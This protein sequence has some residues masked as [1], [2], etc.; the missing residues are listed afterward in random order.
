MTD[1]SKSHKD[2]IP[3][4]E[5]KDIRVREGIA[6]SKALGLDD[7][8]IFLLN[9]EETK[10]QEHISAATSKVK[11]IIL[12]HQPDE[13]FI[14]YYYEQNFDHFVTNRAVISAVQT[15]PKSFHIY[16]Y[17]IWFWRFWPYFYGPI[18]TF[19]EYLHA[20]KRSIISAFRL[21][22]DF[23]CS[24][25]IG[26]VLGAKRN[27][28]NQHRSQMTQLIPNSD[29]PTLV[30]FEN[31]EFLARFFQEYEIFHRHTRWNDNI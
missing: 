3:E 30:N 13:L 20:S 17:P 24:V 31:G 11:E 25:Y 19:R 29:W 28:L 21:W 22:R 16:Q 6:A 26:D 4:D 2:C 9:F 5:L 12:Q 8:N 15:I 1:G 23:R 7:Q 14:P 27:A 18:N 10:L